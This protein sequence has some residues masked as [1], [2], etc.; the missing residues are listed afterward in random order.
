[1]KNKFRL[2][3]EGLN[4]LIAES[5]GS[6]DNELINLLENSVWDNRVIKHIHK[7]HYLDAEYGSEIEDLCSQLHAGQGG[8][9]KESFETT[10]TS[11]CLIFADSGRMSGLSCEFIFSSPMVLSHY[12]LLPDEDK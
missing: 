6:L 3:S 4:S 7:A 2:V 8:H 5:I 9:T 11:K 1:M 10:S 12:K